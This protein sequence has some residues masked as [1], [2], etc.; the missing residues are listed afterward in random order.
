MNFKAIAAAA[1]LLAS[2]T[3]HAFIIKGSDGSNGTAATPQSNSEFIL[4]I[5]DSAGQTYALDLGYS[6]ANFGDGSAA[7]SWT[8]GS[9]IYSGFLANNSGNLKWAVTGNDNNGPTATVG[10]QSYYSTLTLGNST[11]FAFTNA[12]VTS[13][14]GFSTN[15]EDALNNATGTNLTVTNGEALAA[16]STAASFLANS[17][18]QSMNKL[19]N[20]AP[21]GITAGNVV[22]A[23]GVAFIALANSSTSTVAAAQR[24]VFGGTWSFDGTTLSYSGTNT[25]PAVPE[26]GTY[27][28]LIAGLAAVGFVARRRAA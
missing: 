24:T 7:H 13:A 3:S 11:S 12:K 2:A 6:L 26:P 20:Q 1:A 19:G 15:Y 10:T 17:L 21:S 28:M 18:G 22:G 14:S 4:S 16:G 27:A 5:F 25:T 23:S 8:L 9:D